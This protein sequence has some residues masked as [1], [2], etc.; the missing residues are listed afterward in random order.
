MTT[1]SPELYREIPLSRRMIAIV[2][3]AD[4]EWI[5]QWKWHAL[6]T[7]RP[8]QADVLRSPPCLA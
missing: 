7:K 6:S 8:W 4:Y 1:P 2:D 5:N 3:A